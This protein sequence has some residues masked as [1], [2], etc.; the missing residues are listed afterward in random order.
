M[1]KMAIYRQISNQDSQVRSEGVL[2]MYSVSELIEIKNKNGYTNEMIA[3]MTGVPLSTVQ[4]IFCGQTRHPRADTLLEL[5]KGL[6]EYNYDMATY[7]VREEAAEYSVEY[8]DRFEAITNE[9]WPRQGHYTLKDYYALPDQVR[10]ELIDGV[11]YD[12]TAPKPVH[13]DLLFELALEF[14][15]CVEASDSDC[16]VRVAPFDVRLLQDDRNMFEPDIFITCDESK[17]TEEYY[18][19]APE[20]TVE[21][22]SPSTRRKDFLVKTLSYQRAGVRE[23]WIVDPKDK[24]VRVFFFEEDD[25]PTTY[26]FDDRIPVRISAGKCVI[27]FKEIVDKI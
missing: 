5:S 11:I 25:F 17:I 2:T 3:K 24:V 14:R 6:S 26:S 27:D 22:L 10:V 7:A 15:R 9:R 4:K 19:G 23:Y 1:P 8:E 12:M 20:L 21:I 13:Q 18:D 16:K